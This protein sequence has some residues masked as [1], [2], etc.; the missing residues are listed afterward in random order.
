LTYKLGLRIGE[1]HQLN[2]Q[3]I[4]WDDNKLTVHGKGNKRHTLHLDNEMIAILTQ[5][6]AVRKYFLNH[7][8]SSALFISKKGN[9]LA[10]RTI[11]DN[12][13]K[14]ISKLNLKVHFHVTC[15]TL[16]PVRYLIEAL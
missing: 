6:M 4:D 10:I 7:D 14:M 11:E 2:L 3:D 9:R 8:T 12:F 15:H 16:Y 5:W 13:N 1:V